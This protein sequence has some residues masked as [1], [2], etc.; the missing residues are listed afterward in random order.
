[1]RFDHDALTFK[2]LCALD[3]VASQCGA[4]PVKRTF[5]MRFALAY[6]FAVGTGD[7]RC[8]DDFWRIIAEPLPWATSVSHASYYRGTQARTALNGIARSVGY[9]ETPEARERLAVWRAK[10]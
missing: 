10:G 2:A 7:R 8:F 4:E 9:P 6:L 5:A 1:M 3:E